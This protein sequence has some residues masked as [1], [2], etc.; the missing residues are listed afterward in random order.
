[1]PNEDEMLMKLSQLA[2][3][4]HQ[5]RLI[6]F[7]NTLAKHDDDIKNMLGK[8][9]D[10]HRDYLPGDLRRNQEEEEKDIVAPNTADMDGPI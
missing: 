6:D 2:I 7:F 4:R 8:F 9:R 3:S 1:M 5:E 10:K